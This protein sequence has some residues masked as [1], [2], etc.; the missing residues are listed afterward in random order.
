M[1][2]ITIIV[3]LSSHAAALHDLPVHIAA[4]TATAQRG[5]HERAERY[6]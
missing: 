6:G 3:Y 4:G 1:S 5:L 2:E